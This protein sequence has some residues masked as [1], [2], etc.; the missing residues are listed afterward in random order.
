[1]TLNGFRAYCLAKKGVEADFPFD[2]NTLTMR[3]M[4]KMF[5][6]TNVAE[7]NIL[8]ER[9]PSFYSINLKFDLEEVEK[10]REKYEAVIPGYHMNK[11][12]WNSVIIDG[13]ISDRQ[14]KEW[15]DKSYDLIV[16]SLPKKVKLELQEL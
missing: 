10:T 3:V 13:S 5:A 2:D 9:V 1:M 14:I 16:D 15:I 11:K 4:K 12:Y 7:T 6:L 8:G